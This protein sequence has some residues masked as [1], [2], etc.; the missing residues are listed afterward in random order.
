MSTDLRDG[1]QALIEPMSPDKKLR[2][3]EMLVRVGVKEIEVGFPS[4]SQLDFD[5]VR[6][7]VDEGRIPDD[8]TIIVLTQAREELIR[9][10]VEAAAGA[11]RAIVH[12]YNS[13]APV[14]RRVVFNMSREEIVQIAV[15]GTQPRQGTRCQPS[16]DAVGP[17]IL[18]RV[19]LDHR[20]RFLEA[21]R[22]CRQRRVA[23]D[24]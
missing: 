3:F 6:M 18:A 15:N 21:D 12:I 16:A 4:A 9:R 24:P 11:K 1:N 8:V 20:T 13:V 17:R 23:A 7:L 2:F 10:T 22:R 14:F 5:F 19:V